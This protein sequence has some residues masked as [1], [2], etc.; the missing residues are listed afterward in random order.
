MRIIRSAA[1]KTCI[2]PFSALFNRMLF[3]VVVLLDKY[4]LCLV[5]S[6]YILMLSLVFWGTELYVMSP[7]SVLCGVVSIKGSLNER[8]C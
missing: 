1:P 6:E 4:S 8:C 2:F 3:F 7:E 5:V